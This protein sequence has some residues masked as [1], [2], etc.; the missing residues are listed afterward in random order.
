MFSAYRFNSFNFATATT[1]SKSS[2]IL[3]IALLFPLFPTFF[4]RN[5]DMWKFISPKNLL[6]SNPRPLGLPQKNL[7]MSSLSF[8]SSES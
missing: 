4:S 5:F 2:A 7:N 3:L 6:I 1:F 8:P